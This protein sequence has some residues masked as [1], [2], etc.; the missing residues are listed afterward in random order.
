MTAILA[1]AMTL[2]LAVLVSALAQRNVVS[3][4]VLFLLAGFVIGDGGLHLVPLRPE[5]P[6]V[7]LFAE[8]A[9]FSVLFPDGMQVGVRDLLSA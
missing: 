9:L 8:L 6:V 7:S 2:L 1:F 4:A 3:T 5:D